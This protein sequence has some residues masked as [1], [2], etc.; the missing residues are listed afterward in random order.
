MKIF[1]ERLKE[2]RK[3]KGLSQ[4]EVADYLNISSITLLHY[5][6]NQ[7]EPSFDLL[8]EISKYFGVSIDYLFGLTN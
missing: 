1:G 7:R 3:E 8:V 5:E 4:K 2:L 6:K